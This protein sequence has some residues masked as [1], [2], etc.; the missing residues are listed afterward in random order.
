MKNNIFKWFSAR[1]VVVVIMAMMIAM[2]AVAADYVIKM[3]RLSG[4]YTV[5]CEVNGVKKD[6]IFDTGAAHT[7]LSQEFVNELLAK[8]KISKADFVGTT[9]TRNA[10]GVVDNNAT[11]IIK[12]LKVGNRLISNVKAIV[13]V[14]QKAPLLLGLNAIELLGEWSMKKGYLVLHDDASGSSRQGSYSSSQQGTVITP[15]DNNGD[16]FVDSELLPTPAMM[17]Y[18]TVNL[19]EPGVRVAAYR[20]DAQ[21]EYIVG[22]SY[23][24]GDG[25]EPDYDLAVVWLKLAV[26]Q[27]YKPAM[28]A[29]ADCYDYG[30]G[31][32]IDHEQATYLRTM[33]EEEVY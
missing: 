26:R 15:V 27:D 6:F 23:L 29:L 3:K 4:V 22:V 10:S 19:L 31:V 28:R 16:V 9:Q 12:Q 13:A 5:K 33:A 8:R 18:G 32:E 11:V 17:D 2:D 20:G 1:S 30:W 7:S 21:A 25:V 14:A 24:K